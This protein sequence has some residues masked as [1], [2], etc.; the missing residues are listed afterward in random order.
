LVCF[1]PNLTR[2]T[3]GFKISKIS[4]KYKFIGPNF[5]HIMSSLVT[6]RNYTDDFKITLKCALIHRCSNRFCTQHFLNSLTHF[7]DYDGSSEKCAKC[8][9][10][11]CEYLYDGKWRQHSSYKFDEVQFKV[12]L[13]KRKKKTV[14]ARQTYAPIATVFAPV[15]APKRTMDEA[16]G[17]NSTIVSNLNVSEQIH[18]VSTNSS[19]F[20][21]D[22]FLI[23][24]EPQTKL[25][26]TLDISECKIEEVE[27][28][29]EIEDILNNFDFYFPGDESI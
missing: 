16:F 18:W 28:T 11:R 24:E 6:V 20:D 2:N 8:A 29:N 19:E 22:D 23:T 13:A 25:Q 26:K 21:F 7:F 12:S 27:P 1:R 10:G 4:H 3:I 15:P 14:Q 17:N 5:H 9:H